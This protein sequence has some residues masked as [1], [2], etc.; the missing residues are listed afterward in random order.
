[1]TTELKVTVEEETV[2]F[3]REYFPDGI[4]DADRARIAFGVLRHS[5]EREGESLEAFLREEG[6]AKDTDFD[7]SEIYIEAVKRALL[8][9]DEIDLSDLAGTLQS[10]STDS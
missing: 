8:D 2:E 7:L 4:S 3:L 10:D 6:L 9:S 1:M 5:I